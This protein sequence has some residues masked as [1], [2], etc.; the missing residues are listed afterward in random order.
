MIFER[1]LTVSSMHSLLSVAADDW[2]THN[3]Y[4]S[5]SVCSVRRGIA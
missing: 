4:C 3:C 5:K 2:L 1:F